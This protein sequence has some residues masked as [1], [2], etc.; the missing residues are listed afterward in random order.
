[1]LEPIESQ[2][3]AGRDPAAPIASTDADTPDGA[4]NPN[5]A[6]SSTDPPGSVALQV[7]SQ[8]G[9]AVVPLGK[10]VAIEPCKALVPLSKAVVPL[11]GKHVVQRA[12]P[13]VP[14]PR[15]PLALGRPASN[16]AIKDKAAPQ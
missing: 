4:P 1:M 8:P 12:V 5:A 14:A 6:G 9:Q 7:R 16:L 13:Y 11:K 2:V 10:H 15:R 3:P